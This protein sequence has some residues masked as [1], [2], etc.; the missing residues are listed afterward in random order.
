MAR[1]SPAFAGF[2]TGLVSP[3]LDGRTDLQKYFSSCS[4]LENFLVHP[5][6]GVTRRP[7]TR[8][9]AEV[10]TSSAKTRLIPF[11]F[12]VED[13]YIL[14]FGNNY[15]RFYRNNGQI[16]SGSPSAA[17]E[18]STSYTTAQLPALKFAQTGDVMYIVHPEHEISKLSRTAHTSWTLTEVTLTDGAYLSQNTT[19]TTMTSSH[20]TG[21]SRTLTVS[22]TAGV[23]GGDGLQSTDVGRLVTFLAGY[24]QITAVASTTSA[25]ITI[26][27]DFSGTGTSTEWSLGA[28]SDT[29][30]HPRA[31]AFFEERLVFGGT[32]EQPQ[33]VFFSKSG[34]FENFKQGTDADDA[35]IF[36]IGANDVNV[37]RYISS[38]RSLIVGTSGGEFIVSSGT[39]AAITPTNILI[40]KQSNYGSADIQPVQVANVTLFVQRA[41]RKLRELAYEFDTDSYVAPDLTILAEDVTENGIDEL[42]YQQEP[43][44][45]VWAVRG[46]GVLLSLTYRREE[47]VVAWGKHLLGGVSGACTVTVTDYSNIATGTKL[48]FTKSDGNTVTFTSEAAGASSPASSTG[49][50]PNTSNDVTADNIFTCINAHAD[51]TVANPAANVVTIEETQRAGTGFLSVKS[52]DTTR[53]ATT[54]QS[55]ALVESVACIPQDGAEYQVW[56]IVQRTINGATKR[57]VEY[58]TS[59][60]FG[61]DLEDAIFV[62]SSL[63]YAGSSATSMSGLS[64]LEGETVAVTSNGAAQSDKIVAS[65]AITADYAMTVGVAGLRFTST[66][67]TMRIEGGAQS[68]TAQ[69]KSKR[70]HEVTLRLLKTLGAKVGTSSSTADIIPFRSSADEMDE[71]PAMF[72]GDKQIEFDGDFD[73]DGFITVVQEQ[74]LPMTLLALY[75]ELTVFED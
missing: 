24:A 32:S 30:G 52:F 73:S 65:G 28:F 39:D 7:G 31:V 68:G 48:V 18:I 29:T 4:T 55:H 25:T 16:V 40:R 44:S 20:T 3:R 36:T 57:F 59:F 72:T 5:T 35:L 21:S 34:D 22:A 60:D 69:G 75:P 38:G 13:T 2:Q 17:Y 64:H 27:E 12:G 15:I 58:F 46:D 71:P 67:R 47:K 50:R 43:D 19:T 14:E 11:Q 54:D 45:I 8:H 61:T 66:L 6:G 74:A 37:I 49:W 23:N 56:M 63:S 70:I 53:L 1:F 33:T 51:F 42:A 10:K 9:V 62:D 26:L 41:K